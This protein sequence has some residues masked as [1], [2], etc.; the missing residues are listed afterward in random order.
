MAARISAR[1]R[2]AS[3]RCVA[4]ALTLLSAGACTDTPEPSDVASGPPLVTIPGTELHTLSSAARGRDYQISVGLPRSYGVTDAQYPVIYYLDADLGFGVATGIAGTLALGAEI[5][6][7]ILV[8]I[9]YGDV[10][11]EEWGWMRGLDFTPS[12]V[13]AYDASIRE[14]VPDAP[15]VLS[16]EAA[17]FLRFLT[18]ELRP[19]VESRYRVTTDGSGLFGDS[20]GGLFALY[21]LFHSPDSFDRYIVGSPSI[22]WDDAITMRYE[23][24]YAAGHSDL[25]AQVFMSVGLLEEDPDV[26][27]SAAFSM[28]TNVRVLAE[29]LNGRGYPGL[30]VTTHFF[31]GETHLSVVPAN[32]GWGLR[33]LYPPD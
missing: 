26:P 13:S 11:I 29:R 12:P 3:R 19:F 17:G 1:L 22:W 7:A 21:T 32:L 4:L 15:E 31:E 23:E 27:E 20:L 9:G 8:G 28:V 18:E 5:Q 16:G 33:K 24:E 30:T 25:S 14:T 6:E 10:S 2:I